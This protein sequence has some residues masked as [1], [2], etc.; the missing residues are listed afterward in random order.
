MESH[1]KPID[2][3]EISLF[4]PMLALIPQSGDFS[5]ATLGVRS[6]A[7]L[8]VAKLAEILTKGVLSLFVLLKGVIISIFYKKIH[9]KLR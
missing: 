2:V 5:G 4:G 1:R 6:V 8:Q 3:P 9:T 7:L